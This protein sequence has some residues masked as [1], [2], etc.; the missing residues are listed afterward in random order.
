VSN[1]SSLPEVVGDAALLI[2]PNNEEEMAVALHRL[3]SDDT[4]HA[5][6]RAKGLTRARTFTWERAAEETLAVYR[7]TF[8]PAGG[9]T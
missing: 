5:A 6:L 3:L 4:L 2:D 7:R 9:T 1:V 8:D